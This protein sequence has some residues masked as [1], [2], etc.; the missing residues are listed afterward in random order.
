MSKYCHT[1]DGQQ[2]DCNEKY[3]VIDPSTGEVFEQAPEA[4]EEIVNKAV[5]SCQKAFATWSLTPL[6]SRKALMKSAAAAIA[7]K[8]DEIAPVLV[9]EQGKPLASAKGEIQFCAYLF[10]TIAENEIPTTV[11]K[12][13]EKT[14]TIMLRKPVG[15]VAAIAPWNYPAS[16]AL[17]KVAS[18]V[19]TGCT[20]VVKPSPY[21]PLSTLLIGKILAGVFPPGVVNVISGTDKA[22]QLLTQHSGVNKISFTGSIPTGKKI[23]QA[24]GNDLKRVTLELGGNDAAIIRGD[25]SNVPAVAAKVL[26]Y[27]MVNSGQ[28]CAAIKRIYVHE[29]KYEEFCDAISQIASEKFKVGN[30]FEEGVTH[31]PINN[32][33][34]YDKVC[35]LVEDAKKNGA[36]VLCG[37]TPREGKGYFYPITVVKGIQEGVKLVDDEQFGPVVPIMSYKTDEEAIYRANNTKYGLCG[38][39]WTSDLEKGAELATKLDCGTAWVNTHLEIGTAPFGGTKWSGIGR[40]FGFESILAA[41][42][43][44]QVVTVSKA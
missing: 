35:G 30:G 34:Q 24:C 20:I 40:E 4:T 16:T 14:K 37:G 3:D 5:E 6:E 10:T 43:E 26:T 18:A 19:F 29:S 7:A 31:G 12:D 39:V 28:V 15:V 17:V 22:G 42:T 8:V 32:K 38:S 11:L 23:M 36:T 13:N 41:F 2:V 9:K 1:I 44:T 21:T 25:I 33:M 27:S